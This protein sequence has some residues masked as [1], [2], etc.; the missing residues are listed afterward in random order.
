M[1]PARPYRVIFRPGI[2]RTRKHSSPSFCRLLLGISAAVAR[3]FPSGE[4]AVASFENSSS[5]CEPP[6]PPPPTHKERGTQ[7]GREKERKRER[8]RERERAQTRKRMAYPTAC[9]SNGDCVFERMNHDFSTIECLSDQGS[10]HESQLHSLYPCSSIISDAWNAARAMHGRVFR[11]FVRS[12]R[13]S[14]RQR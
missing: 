10:F 11:S 2:V 7:R 8:E 6:P 13:K 1:L 4:P 5:L 12:L 3:V 9:L 14:M